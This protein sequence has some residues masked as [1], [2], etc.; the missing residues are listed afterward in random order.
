MTDSGPMPEQSLLMVKRQQIRPWMFKKEILILYYGLWD[1][2]TGLWSKLTVLLAIV[3]LVNPIDLIP[4]FIPFFGYLDD[5]ILVPLLLNL[6]VFLLPVEVRE[7][8]LVKAS[9]SH[10][11]LQFL[12]SILIVLF[13]AAI[14][15]LFFLIRHL[16][17]MK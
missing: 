9:R 7:E 11:K 15:G 17:N 3:Y 8:S 12:M 1:K 10:K 4:D 5:L 14:I 16:I 13:I 6:A 2:R